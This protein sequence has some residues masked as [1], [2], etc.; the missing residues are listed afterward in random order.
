M[1]FVGRKIAFSQFCWV[2][3]EKESGAAAENIFG[4]V[5]VPLFQ[6]MVFV[7]GKIAFSQFS[8]F[9]TCCV[10]MASWVSES[11]SFEA[12]EPHQESGDFL[13]L[14]QMAGCPPVK[15]APSP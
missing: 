2:R 3:C 1:V 4:A 13:T 12:A 5:W 6:S 8:S 11:A 7:G 15:P 9:R 10:G 14:V